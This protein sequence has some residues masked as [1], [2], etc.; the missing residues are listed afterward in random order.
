MGKSWRAKSPLELVHASICGDMQEPSLGKKFY[1]LTFIDD[2][3]RHTWVYFLKQKSEAFSCF[4][5]FKA[6]AEKQSEYPIK[7]LKTD[8]RGKFTSNEFSD[9]CA[10][11]GIQRQLISAYTPQQN[12]I[13]KRK[14]R[15]IMEMTRSMLQTKNIPN[16]FWG[17]EVAT[18]IYILNRSPMKAV[19]NMTPKEA[20]SGHKPSVAHLRI[21]GCLAYV[22]I[23]DQK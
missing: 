19:Q 4:N 20:W 12:G 21:F 3:S 1:F 16:S 18:T 2:Y 22:H 17:E 13:A 15:T 10:K 6:L 14:N 8:R 7:I 11:N 23:L 9:F 5:N